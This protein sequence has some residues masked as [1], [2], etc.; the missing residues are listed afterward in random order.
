MRSQFVQH[1][2]FS[3][4]RNAAKRKYPHIWIAAFAI[5]LTVLTAIVTV[6]LPKTYEATAGVLISYEAKDPLTGRDVVF[7]ARWM[8]LAPVS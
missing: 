4:I 1:R 3:R 6:A 8:A 5:G 2:L 7:G